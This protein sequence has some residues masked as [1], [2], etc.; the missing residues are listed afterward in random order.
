MTQLAQ[1]LELLAEKR[2]IRPLDQQFARFIAHQCSQD[3]AEV[4]WLAALVSYELGRGHICVPLVDD[5]ER[6]ALAPLLFGHTVAELHAVRDCVALIDWF[7]VIK[8][9]PLIG[10]PGSYLP[11][12][13]DGKRLYLQ[14]YWFYEHQLASRLQ[15]LSSSV[16]IDA[17]QT[18]YLAET[19]NQLFPRPYDALFQALQQVASVGERQRLVCEYLDIVRESALDWTSID[20]LLQQAS[21]GSALSASDIS[22]LDTLVP[23]SVCLNWQKVAAAIALSRRFAVISGGPGTGKTTTVA[24]LLAALVSQNRSLQKKLVIKLVAPTG[25]AAARLTESI[26]QAVE[27]LNISTEVKALIPTQASTLHRLLGAIPNSAEFRHHQRNP[28]HVDLLV[29]DEAS[30][31]DLPMMYKLV[32][33]LPDHARLVLL[34]D[35]DQLASVEAGAVLGD[36]CAF[37]PLGYSRS[38]MAQLARL[39]GY[40]FESHIP[41][42]DV[43]ALADSLCLLQKSYRFHARS[44]IGQLA[45]AVNAGDVSQLL[46]VI[47]QSYTDVQ[48]HGLD[49]ESY[50][51]MLQT[52]VAEYAH[53]LHAITDPSAVDAGTPP[54]KKA[55]YVLRLF[56]R[57]RLLCAIRDGDFGVTGVNQRIERALSRH[58]LIRNSDEP[59]YEGRPVM[60]TRNDHHLEL[61]N[62]DIGICMR[63][64]QDERLKVYFEQFDGHVR[65]FLPSRI[66]QHETAYAMTIHKSQGSEFDF[67]LLLLP[68]EHTPLLTRELVYTGITRAR[69]QLALFTSPKILQAAVRIKTQRVSGLREKMAQ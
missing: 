57:C 51:Q 1:A 9:C 22:V 16:S 6:V 50:H 23:E 32:T 63:D 18:E 47:Q 52:L 3:Q 31:I 42:Q 38:Q 60:I 12:I 27:R 14:R 59:W 7:A 17:A 62:G 13:F 19:L 5:E 69:K 65:G 61:Y 28:L 4:A 54:E 66:P 11:L 2:V 36:I 33:A 30:M 64:P 25:K 48:I 45:K 34:G 43:P 21:N 10:E 20:D 8:R 35:K 24:R 37:Q 41:H 44:G 55:A 29:V 40:Q 46:Q 15:M 67:T 58:Q 39:T 68:P 56:H 26:G 53:Y 49:S